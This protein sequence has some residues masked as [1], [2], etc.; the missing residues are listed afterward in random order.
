[1]RRNTMSLLKTWK[2]RILRSFVRKS[3]DKGVFNKTW[4][5]IATG[6]AGLGF[7]ATGNL[8][9]GQQSI[10]EAFDGNS[11]QVNLDYDN[12]NNKRFHITTQKIS[13]TNAFNSFSN[14]N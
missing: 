3:T 9:W 8:A 4:K 5:K 7:L 13:G 2:R 11:T 14:F 6:I 12:Y 1:A 10:I